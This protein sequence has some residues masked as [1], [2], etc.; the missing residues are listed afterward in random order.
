[1]RRA[2]LVAVMFLV[3][4][5]TARADTL[6]V[7]SVQL[8]SCGAS[9]CGSIS[10][11]LDPAKPT[12]RRIDIAFRWYRPPKT[13]TGPPIVAVEGGPGYPSTGTRVE[14]RGIFGP[15][16]RQRGMLLVDNRGTGGSA[17]I[18]CKSVQ[19]FAGR[20]SG[21]AFARRAGRCGRFLE[22]RF[23]RG[24]SALFATAYAV[25]DL[26]AVL[27]ALR[28]RR[29]DLY[30]DSYGTF[31]VQDFV[32]RHARVLNK[33]VLDSSYPR[34]GTDPW[35]ASSGAAFRLALEKVAPGSLERL[36]A[37]ALQRVRA[38]PIAGETKDADG[39]ALRVRVDPRALADLVQATASDPLALRELDASIRAA[40]AGDDVPL[41]RLTGQAGTWNFSPSE[42]DYFS[43]GAYLAVNC[44]DLPQL[45]DLDASPARR[46]TQLAAAAAPNGAFAPFSAAE[47][48]TISG[49]SQPYDVCLDWPK[50]SNPGGTD[51]D[52]GAEREYCGDMQGSLRRST[53]PRDVRR[54]PR[55]GP[56]PG[57]V[58]RS[59]GDRWAPTLGGCW[60]SPARTRGMTRRIVTVLSPHGA[61]DW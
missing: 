25:D 5:G 58:G 35:Y 50:P 46:R 27:R 14:Y 4:A 29:I 9:Y 16:V 15:L 23:G 61:P 53:L 55:Y 30:G 33:V 59:S 8:R 49:F 44:I 26:A 21:S 32:A 22:R 17:L 28:I 18:D 20:T 37:P 19:S 56:P 43:R 11:P 2:A 3:F 52:G 45:F 39:S 10:R 13:P 1:M 36:E 51:E 38:A 12:G 7:G 24:G 54:G 34:R 48:R 57:G 6:K 47:W 31:F 42:P 40:L 41:L 60:D